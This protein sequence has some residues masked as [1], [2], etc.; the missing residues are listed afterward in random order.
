MT[1]EELKEKYF[2]IEVTEET[3]KT[4]DF[5]GWRVIAMV[6]CNNFTS[7]SPE[8]KTD[9]EAWPINFQLI[10][11]AGMLLASP[12]CPE[13]Y[14]LDS[15]E[16]KELA[17]EMGKIYNTIYSFGIGDLANGITTISTDDDL[18]KLILREPTWT[19][20]TSPYIS[21]IGDTLDT[22]ITC[23]AADAANASTLSTA[24]QGTTTTAA[25]VVNSKLN[26]YN[27]YASRNISGI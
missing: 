13:Q 21:Y 14:Y 23:S 3:E 26:H 5:T 18:Q 11:K 2:L 24:L 19:T 25:S 9:P 27:T 7:V 12:E 15:E 4:K 6:E 8:F 1:Q 20:A 10:Y 16:L 17:G 22:T